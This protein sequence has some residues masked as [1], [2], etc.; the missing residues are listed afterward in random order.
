MKRHASLPNLRQVHLIQ[1]EL[2][3]ALAG[4][5][6]AVSPGAL[7]ENITTQ[8]ID[9]LNLPLGTRLRLGATAEIRLTGLRVP[10]GYIDKLRPGLKRKMIIR[11]GDGPRYW[12]R[13]L[14]PARWHWVMLSRSRFQQSPGSPCPPCRSPRMRWRAVLA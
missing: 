2:F 10:C 6:Y 7:G 4:A 11:G 3:E 1:S 8:G 9:L 14:R 5:G 12:L 13:W